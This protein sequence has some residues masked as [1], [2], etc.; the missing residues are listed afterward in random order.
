MLIANHYI[1]GSIKETVFIERVGAADEEALKQYDWPGN[2]RELKNICERYAAYRISF[3]E[4]SVHPLSSFIDGTKG[5]WE[6]PR[7]TSPNQQ[8]IKE[9]MRES[10]SSLITAYLREYGYNRGKVAEKLGISRQTLWR[11][12]KRLGLNGEEN[13]HA[14]PAAPPPAGR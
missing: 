4:S 14:L 8:G 9:R 13:Q 2:I 5:G 11:R 6:V 7:E 10:E 1:R 12:M 3:P